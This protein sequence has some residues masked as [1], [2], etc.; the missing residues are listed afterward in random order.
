MCRAPGGGVALGTGTGSSAGLGAGV[1]WW[2]VV[3]AVLLAAGLRLTRVARGR[4][5]TTDE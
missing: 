4:R 5:A 2:V 1:T 3:G